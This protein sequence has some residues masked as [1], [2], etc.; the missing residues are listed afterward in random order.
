M[1]EDAIFTHPTDLIL[2]TKQLQATIWFAR[3]SMVAMLT[4]CEV[5]YIY[6]SHAD[7]AN[8]TAN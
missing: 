5:I 7:L 8:G 2:Q 1:S 4:L 6:R 3:P